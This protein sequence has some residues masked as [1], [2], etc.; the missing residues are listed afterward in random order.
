MTEF[1][2]PEPAYI[3]LDLFPAIVR[4]DQFENGVIDRTRVIVTDAFVYIFQDTQDGPAVVYS[5]ELVGISGRAT[6]GYTAELEE[7]PTILIRR[8]NGCG[9]G[10]R[11]PGIRPFPGIG[12]VGVRE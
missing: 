2:L 4:G 5:A 12:H 10:S 7:E 6:I 1:G 11:L 8:S 3:R 9:C